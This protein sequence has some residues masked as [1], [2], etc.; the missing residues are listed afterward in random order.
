MKHGVT[1]A[2]LLIAAIA[3]SFGQ[4]ATKPYTVISGKEHPEQ[5]DDAT[6]YLHLFGT[7]T[8][9]QGEPQ[10][11]YDRRRLAYANQ[12][13]LTGNEIAS[14]LAGADAYAQRLQ[15]LSQSGPVDATSRKQTALSVMAQLQQTLGSHGAFVLATFV[16]TAVKP[17]VTIYNPIVH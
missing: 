4:Q 9:K 8:R 16:N 3:P 7:L 13:G 17:N 11:R 1:A 12:T 15:T 14:L 6:A 5:I 10:D 2:L